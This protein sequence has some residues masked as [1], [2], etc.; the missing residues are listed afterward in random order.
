MRIQDYKSITMNKPY[1]ENEQAKF[2]VIPF[3]GYLQVKE[4]LSDSHS[5]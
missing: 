1:R 3:E 2:A 5:V 4:L